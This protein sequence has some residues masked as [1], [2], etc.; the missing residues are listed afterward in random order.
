M[1][2][3][4][5]DKK[6][7]TPPHPQGDSAKPTASEET[8]KAIEQLRLAADLQPND[9]ETHQLLVASLDQAATRP[10]PA[11]IADAVNGEATNEAL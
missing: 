5:L 9:A 1:R 6:Q 3:P 11:A 8:A 2:P 10:A 4:Q 7:K